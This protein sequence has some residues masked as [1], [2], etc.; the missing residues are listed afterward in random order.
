MKLVLSSLLVV[1]INTLLFFGLLNLIYKY[2]I[3][4]LINIAVALFD[5][6]NLTSPYYHPS[7]MLLIALLHYQYI[8]LLL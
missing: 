3:N 6:P 8:A 4:S 1:F 2:T 5:Y 7:Q